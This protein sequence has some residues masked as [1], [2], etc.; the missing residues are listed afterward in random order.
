M[1]RPSVQIN[2]PNMCNSLLAHLYQTLEQFK[3]LHGVL[4]ITLNGGLARGYGDHLSEIDVTLYLKSDVYIDWQNG[5][6][7]L[8]VGIQRIN[9]ALYDIKIA[10]TSNENPSNWS[11]DARW[12]ASYAHILYDPSDLVRTL[13]SQNDQYRPTPSDAVGT[14]FGAWWYFKLAGDIWIYRDDPLQAHF[15]LNQAV[16]ELVKAVYMANSEFVPHEKW[17]IHMSRTLSW[18]P[19]DWIARLSGIMCNTA[20]NIEHVESRQHN[21]AELW[22]EI[23]QHMISITD[24]A[25]PLNIMHKKHYELLTL[26]VEKSPL[27]LAEWEQVADLSMLNQAPFNL[28]VAVIENAVVLNHAKLIAITP[29]ELYSWHYAIVKQIIA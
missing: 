15:I 29:E 1:G 4:G 7:P 16:T 3:E 17:L 8:G 12:D 18:T 13:L 25:Y 5:Q 27:S 21:I 20:P 22:N 19:A 6:A 11:P 23:D 24:E 14:M 28:C 2:K 9:G 26:L 10:N